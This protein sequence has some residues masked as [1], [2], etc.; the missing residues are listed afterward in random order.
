[1][2][3]FA[4]RGE[5]GVGDGWSYRR[6]ARLSHTGRRLRRRYDVHFHLRHF[7]D[8]QDP[9]AVEIVLLDPAILECDRSV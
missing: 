9:I 6:H 4:C 3:A 2:D 1:M 5:Y 8:A 7:I